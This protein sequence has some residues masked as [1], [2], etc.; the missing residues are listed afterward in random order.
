LKTNAEHAARLRELVTWVP[1]HLA[2]HLVAAAEALERPILVTPEMV[3]AGREA[4]GDCVG[5]CGEASPPDDCSIRDCI[6][7]ALA[8]KP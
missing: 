5:S 3:A 4:L 8:A 6:E 2:P 7:A 1:S